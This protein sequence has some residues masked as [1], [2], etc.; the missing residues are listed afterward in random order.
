MTLQNS[1][2]GIAI[3]GIAGI[4]NGS[5]PA[6]A[7]RITSW[8]WEHIWFVYSFWAMALL[9]V[10]LAL[11]F[12][13]GVIP[14]VLASEPGPSAKVA[15]FGALWG[16]GSLLFGV[17]LV[18]LGMAVTNALVNGIV[19]FLGSLGPVLMGAVRLGAHQLVWLIGGLTLLAFS[20]VLCA[21]AS[22]SRDRAERVSSSDA[23]SGR[24]S[25]GAVSIAV[26]AGILSS[27]LNI[28]FVYGAPLADKAKAVGCPLFLSTV[29]IWVPVLLGGLILNMGYPAYLMFRKNS[30]STLLTRNGNIGAWL[31]SSFMGVLWFGAILLYGIGASIMGRG[32]TVY[33]WALIVAV[34]ILTSNTWGALT[35]EWKGSGFKPKFLMWLSTVVLIGSLIIL[36]GQ[37]MNA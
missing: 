3:V 18:R 36:A 16:V 24:Q 25:I 23:I 31:G 11:L 35:G 6:P 32:G 7:K 29:T 30:W 37:Q 12:S 9:P 8:K 22:L 20:L 33:G 27:M 34:S 19:V 14:R 2:R 5:F 4:S 13:H 21:G 10:G 15:V 1:M 28:G 26:V 17:S